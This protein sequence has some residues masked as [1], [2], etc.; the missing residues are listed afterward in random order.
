MAPRLGLS[1][2]IAANQKTPEKDFP[3]I[4]V[5]SR[6]HYAL[7]NRAMK[8]VPVIAAVFLYASAMSCAAQKP[9]TFTGEIDKN[10]SPRRHPVGLLGRQSGFAEMGF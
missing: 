7:A 2:G 1:V 10:A 3:G 6:T 4:R 8:K 9:Q 5:Y